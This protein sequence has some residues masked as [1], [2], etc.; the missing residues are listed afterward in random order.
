MVTLCVRVDVHRNK[1]KA[2]SE[3]LSGEPVH[4]QS[5][6]LY[7][8][9]V[10]ADIAGAMEDIAFLDNAS[11]SFQDIE[12]NGPPAPPL[13]FEPARMGLAE[14]VDA[15][16][17][18]PVT[19]EMR[20]VSNIIYERRLDGRP[21]DRAYWV[22]RK[23]KK[24]IF[25]VVKSCTVLKFRNQH[26]VPWEVT[27]HRAA[28]KI[29][30][31]QKIRELRHIEDPQKEVAAM[32]HISSHGTHPHVM[33]PLDLLQ[34]EDYLLMFMPYCSS[35][36]LFTFVQQAGK[37]PEPLARFWFRQILEVILAGSI[38]C[39]CRPPSHIMYFCHRESVICN[40]WECVIETCH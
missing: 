12:E 19:H 8:L 35:G 29:M 4:Q 27:E 28:V 18:N 36:D 9:R 26:D 20:E 7:L 11:A 21:P 17:Y 13:A 2:G 3:L 32:Q 38:L 33:A 15:A 37:F 39:G 23:L 22:G 1:L 14:R 6:P 34:D 40:E 25:G 30:S 31:W 10:S 5:Q 24:C 16:V